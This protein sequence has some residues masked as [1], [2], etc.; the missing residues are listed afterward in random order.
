[1]FFLIYPVPAS[2]PLFYVDI[3]DT[4]HRSLTTKIID[5]FSFSYIAF[6]FFNKMKQNETAEQHPK[7]I[8]RFRKFYFEKFLFINERKKSKK[9][10]NQK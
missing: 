4:E 2:I 8:I 9:I 5:C 3:F 1:V 7:K 6:N 10:Q